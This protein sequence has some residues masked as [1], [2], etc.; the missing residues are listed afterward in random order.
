MV[1]TYNSPC[2]LIANQVAAISMGISVISNVSVVAIDVHHRGGDDSP[3]DPRFAQK[4]KVATFWLARF[5]RCLH[6]GCAF[7]AGNHNMANI[8]VT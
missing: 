5:V 7:C 1:Q 4:G 2:F 6:R 3:I 8:K